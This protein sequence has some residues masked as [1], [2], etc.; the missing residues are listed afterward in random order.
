MAVVDGQ[1][2]LAD[3]R[4]SY[5]RTNGKICLEKPVNILLCVFFFIDFA[6]LPVV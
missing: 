2:P 3:N 6:C 5:E 4:R 1:L